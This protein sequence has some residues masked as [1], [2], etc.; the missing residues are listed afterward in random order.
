MNSL[1]RKLM[2]GLAERERVPYVGFHGAR[3]SFADV[4]RQNGAS[5]YTIS[6]ALGHSSIAVTET[7]L[8]AFGR[9]DVEVEMRSTFGGGA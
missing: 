6:K 3:H 5:V 7:Y 8:A 2:R 9:A 4:L 1:A